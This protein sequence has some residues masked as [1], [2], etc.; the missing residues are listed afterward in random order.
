M[1]PLNT[2]SCIYMQPEKEGILK[3]LVLYVDDMFILSNDLAWIRTIK[4]EL[5]NA[6]KLR[7][8]E[9]I[10]YA[11][12]IKFAQNENEGTI[13]MSQGSYHSRTFETL[14]YAMR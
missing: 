10:N 2:D 9:R 14:R 7:D 6:F 8:L 5:V 13:M 3:L 11:L 12:G 1:N 4:A